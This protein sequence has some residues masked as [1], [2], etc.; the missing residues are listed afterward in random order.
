MFHLSL[1]RG[2]HEKLLNKRDLLRL[3]K[4]LK[5]NSTIMTRRLQFCGLA[6]G[7]DLLQ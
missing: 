3:Y 1:T 7:V 4:N 2:R 5:P 6:I